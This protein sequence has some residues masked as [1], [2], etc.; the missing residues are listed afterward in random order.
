MPTSMIQR[1]PPDANV[2]FGHVRDLLPEHNALGGKAVAHGSDSD[3]DGDADAPR[4]GE[5][6]EGRIVWASMA[7]VLVHNPVIIQEAQEL[8]G[9]TS[10]SADMWLV[11][12]C[13]S[14]EFRDSDAKEFWTVWFPTL[15]G[16]RTMVPRSEMLRDRPSVPA[17]A[18]IGD[19]ETLPYLE[20][21]AGAAADEEQKLDLTKLPRLSTPGDVDDD[22]AVDD[23][24]EDF[25][26]VKMGNRT[27]TWKVQ[28][29]PPHAPTAS[30]LPP[31]CPSA[32]EPK[33]PSAP[34]APVLHTLTAAHCA[35]CLPCMLLC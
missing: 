22:A 24:T 8:S 17:A 29:P 2:T 33:C 16:H 35:G 3:E 1:T 14:L 28:R 32:P 27:V 4:P 9:G 25:V 12:R 13:V 26:Q 19:L 11:G 10:V 7:T 15:P 23:V 5:F 31:Q 21:A 18:I 34:S 6:C 30:P 20:P